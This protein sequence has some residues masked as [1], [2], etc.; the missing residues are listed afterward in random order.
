[1]EK[2]LR[3]LNL[4]FTS[5]TEKNP[6]DFP[7]YGGKNI[8]RRGTSG[9]GRGGLGGLGAGAIGLLEGKFGGEAS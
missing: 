8:E 5:T 4:S 6:C 2:N 9:R 3:D 1:M 7:G